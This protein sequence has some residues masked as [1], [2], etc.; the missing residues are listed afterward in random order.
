MG[1]QR[2]LTGKGVGKMSYVR[3]ST[4]IP[5]NEPCGTCKRPWELKGLIAHN[6]A[7]NWSD[8]PWYARLM[9]KAIW[10]LGGKDT[11][12]TK[13]PTLRGI[14]A[15]LLF[16]V[17]RN[18]LCEECSSHWYIFDHAD[19]GVAVWNNTSDEIPFFKR[20][21]VI[22]I[23]DKCTW[24]AIPGWIKTGGQG[25]LRPAL[26]DWLEDDEARVKEL[27]EIRSLSNPEGDG[28]CLG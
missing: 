14:W 23:L 17:P 16:K 24:T 11:F 15:K 13:I 4:P 5:L 18:G 19:D 27:A 1:S 21:E 25:V 3:W 26:E 7:M 9:T 22:D 10:K 20:E 6:Y 8:G 2:E 28:P 12:H